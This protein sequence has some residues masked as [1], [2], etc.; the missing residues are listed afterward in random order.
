MTEHSKRFMAA[1]R[2]CTGPEPIKQRL[3]NAWLTFLHDVRPGELPA[4]LQTEF[5]SLRKAMQTAKPQP[6]ESAA[7][8]SVRKMSD[9]QAAV[10]TAAILQLASTLVQSTQR[11]NNAPEAVTELIFDHDYSGYRQ[12]N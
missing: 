2:I 4:G 9:S 11:Q 10:H 12:L 5:R 8:A 3:V 1:A 6:H 7:T